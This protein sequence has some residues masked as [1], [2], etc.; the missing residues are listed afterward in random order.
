MN[1]MAEYCLIGIDISALG[2]WILATDP[3]TIF[4]P[5][6]VLPL[7][8]LRVCIKVSFVSNPTSTNLLRITEDVRKTSFRYQTVERYL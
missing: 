6:G 2:P 8:F 7:R 4:E 5:C 3:L 1:K